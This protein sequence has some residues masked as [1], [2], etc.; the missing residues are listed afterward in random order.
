MALTPARVQRGDQPP[1][2]VGIPWF[3]NVAK[4]VAAISDET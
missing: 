3:L 2:I 1:Q 4:N